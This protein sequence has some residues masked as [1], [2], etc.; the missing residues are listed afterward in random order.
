[1]D[2]KWARV[3]MAKPENGGAWFK[4]DR[5][6][7]T[8]IQA[9]A[10]YNARRHRIPSLV[11]YKAHWLSKES[12][13][14][15][16]WKT[17]DKLPLLVPEVSYD[18]FQNHAVCYWT[19]VRHKCVNLLLYRGGYPD[20]NLS[21]LRPADSLHDA[22]QPAQAGSHLFTVSTTRELFCA[23]KNRNKRPMSF[24]PGTRIR[25]RG[26][27]YKPTTILKTS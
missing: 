2:G 4:I 26:R 14:W 25:R 21:A 6:I 17:S 8:V 18:G 24:A 3:Q 7:K 20:Q 27:T 23:A 16:T 11:A 12:S 9:G 19:R 22:D 1:V 13:A 10:L 5:G 15:K